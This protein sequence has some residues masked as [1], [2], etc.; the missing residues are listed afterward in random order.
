MHQKKV[1]SLEGPEH[2]NVTTPPEPPHV[3]IFVWNFPSCPRQL[4]HILSAC[5]LSGFTP[6]TRVRAARPC[7]AAPIR[8]FLTLGKLLTGSGCLD[9]IMC[10]TTV[11]ADK[12][13]PT[14]W[15]LFGLMRIFSGFRLGCAFGSCCNVK[16][17]KWLII[18][19]FYSIPEK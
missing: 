6:T 10:W 13:V 3:R 1:F 17:M 19:F 2:E 11:N 16:T 8:L 7:A 5:M 15:F 4:F 18:V 9:K 12:N 14:T